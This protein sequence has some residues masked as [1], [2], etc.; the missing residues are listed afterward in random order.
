M[1][2]PVAEPPSPSLS[3]SRCRRCR[4]VLPGRDRCIWAIRLTNRDV[5]QDAFMLC[6]SCTRAV[7]HVWGID[8]S[9]HLL[10]G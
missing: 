8:V 4:Q 2:S 10:P 6:G 7:M 3:G 1:A 5:W 9:R